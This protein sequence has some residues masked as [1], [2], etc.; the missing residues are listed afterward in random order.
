MEFILQVQPSTTTKLFFDF[1]RRLV[2]GENPG[3]VM[4]NES[5]EE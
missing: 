5:V 4:S 2:P 1:M 3:R